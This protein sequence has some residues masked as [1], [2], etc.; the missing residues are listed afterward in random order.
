MPSSYDDALTGLEA[1]L[2][3]LLGVNPTFRT[4]A[5]KQDLLLR[6]AK[7]RARLQALEMTVLATAD[8]VAEATGARSTA[9]WL[10]QELRDAPGRLREEARLA[11]A[12]DT[13]WQQVAAAFRTGVINLPQVR[14]IDKALSDLPADLGD[15]VVAKAEEFLVEKAA[16]HGPRELAVLGAGVLQFLAPEI[17]DAAELARL[18]AEEERAAATTRLWFHRRG[19]GTTDLHARLPDHAANR[20]RTYVAA[21]ANPHR[22]SND[23]DFMALPL[24]RR[25]GIAFQSLLETV[26]EKD[27]PRHGQTATS[28]V[29]TTPLDTL[30]T[31]LGT[32]T[33]STGDLLTAG[34]ARRLACQAGIL[35]A[36]LDTESAVLD[37]GRS[38]RFFT[39]YLRKAIDL[40]DQECTVRD[41]HIPAAYCHA[42]HFR[43]PWAKG[44]RTSLAD[45]KLLGPFH[46]GRAHDDNWD[47]DHH[48]D[49]STTF[50]RRPVTTGPS[51]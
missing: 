24:E 10:A 9:A 49:G 25:R 26:L 45:G 3:E 34:Q 48:S 29:V 23:D 27:L 13:R 46:H 11:R 6:A 32:A 12:L 33:T 51:G 18:Q 4:T 36:V 5:E 30:V 20:L 1:C 50:T 21:I 38:A 14:A 2:D 8:D 35:P 44:G 16:E 22:A 28:V 31:G 42:H 7:A 41:C 40:R 39:G 19:D 47:T 15:D 43:R 17:A 37:L